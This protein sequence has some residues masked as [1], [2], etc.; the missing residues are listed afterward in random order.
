MDQ[1]DI[2]GNIMRMAE[3]R[4]AAAAAAGPQAHQPT[5]EERIEAVLSTPLFMQHTPTEREMEENE[6]L[7]ALQSLTFDGLPEEVAENFK[8]QGNDAFRAGPKSYN[9]AIAFYTKGIA[10][11]AN[12][13]KLNSILYSNRAAVNLELSNFRQVLN[14]CA[15]AIKL[16]P[17][18]VKAFFRSAAALHKLDRIDEGIDCCQKGLELEPKN[19]QLQNILKSLHNRGAELKAIEEKRSKRFSEKAQQVARV[20]ATLA[21]RGYKMVELPKNRKNTRGDDNSSDDDDA[22]EDDGLT[23]L[24]FPHP[25]APHQSISLDEATGRLKFPVLFVYPEYSQSDFI[26]DF[27]EDDA[28][29]DHFQ[30]IFETQ[31]P[32]DTEHA[33]KPDTLDLFYET[34]ASAAP[35]GV[36]ELVSVFRNVT[37]SALPATQQSVAHRYVHTTLGDVLRHPSFQIVDRMCTFLIVMLSLAA[38]LSVLLLLL[39]LV[40]WGITTLVAHAG[41][42]QPPLGDIPDTR[43]ESVLLLT[44]HPDDECLFFAPTIQAL[45]QSSELHVLCLSN[46]NAE[47]LGRI[48]EKEL[49]ASCKTLGVH[50]RNVFSINHSLLQDS[51]TIDWPLDTIIQVVANH[52]SKHNIDAVSDAQSTGLLLAAR[53]HTNHKALYAAMK[54]AKS[55]K[56]ITLPVY[57]LTTISVLRKFSS[58]IDVCWTSLSFNLAAI[59]NR[60]NANLSDTPL[61]R[62]FVSSPQDYINACTAMFQHSS[63]LVWFRYLYIVFSRYMIINE[64]QEL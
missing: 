5:D 57:T 40:G 22:D 39:P 50:P 53:S 61:K 55:S 29:S 54:L 7:A 8:N 13:D 38:A 27:N 37:A 9:D 60:G 41:G 1:I 46:G 59:I 62:L 19:S 56:R 42:E 10:A 44:A 4:A 51:M 48:R 26:T 3:E 20:K 31:A 6:T 23:P 47:G 21:E 12:D 64:L 36:T 32:W 15:A 17:K 63:Q 18:N 58:L 33:Y 34:H 14:D 35:G 24:G 49:L 2:A 52:I 30:S 45:A 43:R 25:L 11:K 28:F 16:N